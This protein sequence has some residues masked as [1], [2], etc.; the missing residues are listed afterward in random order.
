[1]LLIVAVTVIAV[2]FLSLH[3]SGFYWLL[4][5][6]CFRCSLEVVRTVRIFVAVVVVAKVVIAIA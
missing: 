5:N 3:Y 1:M 6:Y 4:Q 2:M